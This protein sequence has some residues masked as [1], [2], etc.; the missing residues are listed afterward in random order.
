MKKT[1]TQTTLESPLKKINIQQFCTMHK[2]QNAWN[3]PEYFTWLNTLKPQQ[4]TLLLKDNRKQLTQ[5]L[6]KPSG[7]FR[8]EFL[9]HNWVFPNN[10]V[11][12]TATGKG[13][14]IEAP[15][16]TST[17]ELK[18]FTL[19]IIQLLAANIVKNNTEKPQVTK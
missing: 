13:T 16:T 7:F 15:V 6:G 3:N 11:I 2:L 1:P 17:E 14:G 8:G 5:I 10:I 12:N 4:R 9:Y 19:K 18:T